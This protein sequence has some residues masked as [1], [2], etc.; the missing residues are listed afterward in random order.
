MTDQKP[1]RT[2]TLCDKDGKQYKVNEFKIIAKTSGISNS[3]HL[4]TPSYF[5]TIDGLNIELENG[6]Y[7][8]LDKDQSKT[9]LYNQ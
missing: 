6:I 8:L 5:T 7:Y 1:I 3:A 2:F 4:F 9:Q